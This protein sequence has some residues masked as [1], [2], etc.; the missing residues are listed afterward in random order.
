[1]NRRTFLG[2]SAFAAAASYLRLPD[3]RRTQHLIFMVNGGG[4]RKQEYYENASLSPNI[5]QLAR[6]GFVFE[7]DHCER[8]AS[9]DAAYLELMQ[10]REWEKGSSYPTILD[11]VGRG[12][13]VGTL[14]EVPSAMELLRP[15]LLVCGQMT[16]DA[17]H[18]SYDAYLDAVRFTDQ[19]VGKVIQW[20]NRHPYFR[21]KTAIVIRPEFGR[22]DELNSDGHLHHSYGFPSTHRVASIFWG[23]DFRQG[24]D[25]STVIQSIDMAPTLA[26]VF[27]RDAKYSRGRILPVFRENLAG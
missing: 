3:S 7:Q 19:G 27:N 23:P 2:N 14:D 26:S 11:Y 8:V 25:R 6:E 9:H 5:T 18:Q 4:V 17:G 16:H 12:H 20:L 22:D 24:I 1:M 15:R 21:G 13:R 10:G